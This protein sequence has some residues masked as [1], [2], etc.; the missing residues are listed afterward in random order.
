MEVTGEQ[1]LHQFDKM[2][3]FRDIGGFRTEEGSLMKSGILFRSDHL[4]KLSEKDQKR[5]QELEVKVV[6]DLRTQKECNS[7]PSRI[8]DH[9][10][11]VNVPIET[12]DANRKLLFGFLFRK[13]GEEEFNR[14]IRDYYSRITFD[15]TRQINEVLSVLA[16]KDNLPA[17]IHC[18]AGKDR[19]GIISAFIQLAVGV[20][21][22]KVVENYLL[23]NKY[24]ENRLNQSIKVMRWM[25][26]FRV[27]PERMKMILEAKPE[28]L[29]E[30]YKDI[31][32]QYGSIHAYLTDACQIDKQV[33]YRLKNLL[34]E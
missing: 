14:F 21:Y 27:T 28:Y 10:Q 17:I 34:L 5:I 31:Q 18:T 33:I 29:D 24:Y 6:C 9:I 25:T 11:I 3:N 32:K 26:L 22:E 2:Y 8:P 19:T 13:T 16:N 15:K 20:P 30:V 7:K 23:T 12:Q 1:W 4:S